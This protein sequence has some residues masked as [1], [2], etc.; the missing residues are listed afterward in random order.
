MKKKLIISV[1][2]L[3]LIAG[4]AFVL[5]RPNNVTAENTEVKTTFTLKKVDLRKTSF[6]DGIVLTNQSAN[7]YA[8]SAT[9]VQETFVTEGSQVKAGDL[10]ATLDTSELEKSLK[11]AN[12]QLKVDLDKLED[13]KTTGNSSLLAN[14]QKA[15]NAYNQAKK[16]LTDN[17]TLFTAGVITKTALDNSQS[18]L[19]NAYVSYVNA[20]DN[21][22]TSNL[23][24]E[25]QQL[26][27]KVEIDQMT[28]DG[29]IDDIAASTITAPFDG[30]II[31]VIE[32]QD[33]LINKGELLY[34]IENLDQLKVEANVSEYEINQVQLGQKVLIEPLAG[35]QTYQGIVSYIAPSGIISSSEVNIPIQID[36]LD[37]D[38]LI[39]PNFSVNLE[40]ETSVKT[41]VLA[42]PYEAILDTPKGSFVLANVNGSEQM[43]PVT[44][45]ASSDLM[46]EIIS[47]QLKEGDQV[48]M[49]TFTANRVPTET[50]MPMP[51]MGMRN[52]PSTNGK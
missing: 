13:L 46:V 26:T 14:Y 22:N 34:T 30:T 47:D 40:I 10:L 8:P 21:M 1:I 2:V 9:T 39:K 50:G 4:G 51:G 44:K 42:V 38:Q 45:G 19:D 12:Y 33:K 7:I 32:D 37:E 27:L 35:S 17:Q 52:R 24:N 3:A 29:L 36:I 16:D 23:D 43:I 49:T 6:T 5:L 11:N 25:I 18:S 15:L 31:R 20:K 28:I 48:I 41:G